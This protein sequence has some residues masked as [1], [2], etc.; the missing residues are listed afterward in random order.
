MFTHFVVAAMLIKAK[1]QTKDK[2][3][4]EIILHNI[5]YG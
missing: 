2:S 1:G 5:F 4:K 3:V